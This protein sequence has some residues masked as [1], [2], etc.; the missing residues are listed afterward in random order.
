[1]VSTIYNVLLLVLHSILY[2][3][4]LEQD[5]RSSSVEAIVGCI[6]TLIS[7]QIFGL[8]FADLAHAW[9]HRNEVAVDQIRVLLLVD[10]R[11]SWNEEKSFN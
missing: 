3:I 5:A 6:L 8:N 1:M 11:V 9:L 7:E 4:Q 2:L 10:S